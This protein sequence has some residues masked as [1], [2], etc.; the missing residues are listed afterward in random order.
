MNSI[1]TEGDNEATAFPFWII[2]D[3][4]QNMS[5][6]VD[7]VASQI[8]GVW[9]SRK[10]AKEYLGSHSYNFSKRARVYCHTGNKSCDYREAIEN[11]NKDTINE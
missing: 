10:S 9:F 5:C 1:K 11:A 4:R 2:I 6:S 3:P 8:T 7:E